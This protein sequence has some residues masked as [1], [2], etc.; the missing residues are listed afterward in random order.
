M[1]HEQCFVVGSV[2]CRGS[3]FRNEGEA[4]IFLSVTNVTVTGRDL[5]RGTVASLSRR[6]PNSVHIAH[7]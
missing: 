4:E 5:K 7:V 3:V 6:A 2:S 1:A